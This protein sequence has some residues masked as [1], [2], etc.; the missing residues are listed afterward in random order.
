MPVVP[1]R[2]AGAG[3]EGLQEG[4]GETTGDEWHTFF[5][6]FHDQPR[7]DPTMANFA[8]AGTT[9]AAALAAAS[10]TG[11]ESTT[12]QAAEVV[13]SMEIE[14]AAAAIATKTAAAA[15]SSEAAAGAA[16]MVVEQV[17]GEDGTFKPV[18]KPLDASELRSN[19]A[20]LRRIRVPNHRYT[21]LRNS[22]ESIV[23][24]IVVSGCVWTGWVALQLIWGRQESSATS[25]AVEQ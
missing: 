20:E 18:F 25:D 11:L 7:T 13:E 22:W 24:P 8:A 19:E 6:R 23:R 10:S 16:G 12:A 4:G 3:T 5:L 15:A 14:T 2:P 17:Q 9:A 21:P 1:F